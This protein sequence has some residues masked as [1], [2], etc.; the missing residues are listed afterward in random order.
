MKEIFSPYVLG[1]INITLGV[2]SF[3][4]A[5]IIITKTIELMK[6]H[7]GFIV[8]T[9]TFGIYSVVF[10]I[11]LLN[12]DR[13]ETYLFWGRVGFV[14]AFVIVSVL[15]LSYYVFDKRLTVTSLIAIYLQAVFFAV[16][17][18]TK[19]GVMGVAS[20]YPLKRIMGLF[21]YVFR[22]WIIF[23]LAFSMYNFINGYRK[24]RGTKKLQ[25]QYILIG[26][27]ITMAMSVVLGVMLPLFGKSGLIVFTPL[28]FLLFYIPAGYAILKRNLLG[29]ELVA[30]DV[31]RFIIALSV[32]LVLN[33]LLLAVSR[34]TFVFPALFSSSLSLVIVAILYFATPVEKKFNNII[35]R[36]LLNRR[37]KYQKLL[38]DCSKA[39]TSILEVDKLLQHVV[40]S[41]FGAL[42]TKKIAIFLKEKLD[43]ESLFKL[44]ASHGLS[45]I[46]KFYLDDRRVMKWLEANK[47][48]FIIDRILQKE[49]KELIDF[50]AVFDTVLVIPLV[51]KNEVIGI[52]T[53]DHKRAD[54][55]IFD[56]DDIEVLGSLASSLAVS[57]EN[58]KLYTNLNNAYMDI[59]RSLAIAVETRDPLTV[60]H[61][62]NVTKYALAVSKKMNI[63]GMDLIHII[64]AAMVHDLGKI[65]VHDY[66]LT[67]P[68]ELT[69]EEW[70]EMK[71]H[72]VKGAKILEPLPFM[73]EVSEIIRHHHERYDGKGYPEGL[74]GY[75]IP[76]GAQILTV[77]DAFDAMLSPRLYRPDHSRSF[78]LGDTIEELKNNKGT[79]F[80]PKVV[81]VLI[82]VITENQNIVR[83]RR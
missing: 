79:Q 3:V 46:K 33:F 54:G 73:K 68:G 42:G 78:S 40:A 47:R 17:A 74:L 6:M 36:V 7:I 19:I 48:P 20:I 55:T 57:L 63:T 44:Y 75:Q 77:A 15:L 32:L 8:L 52:I 71:L 67:K 35:R 18:H 64:Q 37:L 1:I 83:H 25:L 13:P 51:Y 22:F 45:N 70:V 82:E 26:L 65:G 34:N 66:I 61:S 9:V 49:N 41:L 50:L 27:I 43:N 80:S 81:D 12:Y 29:V 72:T 30:F 24:L 21:G 28:L 31:V 58:A 2:G 14:S 4:F 53:L 23:V 59:T 5:A 16:I 76:L 62:E 60:G 39:V 10:G 38:S 56:I 69:P 11:G